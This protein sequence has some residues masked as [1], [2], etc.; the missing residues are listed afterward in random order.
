MP[1]RGSGSRSHNTAGPCRAALAN[2]P[3][4]ASGSCPIPHSCPAPWR[5]SPR[6]CPGAP[7][8]SGSSVAPCATPAAPR[9]ATR[10][11]FGGPLGFLCALV[12]LE[13]EFQRAL[14]CVGIALEVGHDDAVAPGAL[15]TDIDK[16]DRA[17][18]QVEMRQ[19]QL[20]V[21]GGPT[22]R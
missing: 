20:L 21:V 15:D 6:R 19:A 14:E 1:R 13:A 10:L 4:A 3:S 8:Q 18:D 2:P 12:D 16:S 9:R 7:R 5:R 22:G 11:R 17:P